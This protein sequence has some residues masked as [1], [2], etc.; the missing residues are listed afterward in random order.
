MGYIVHIKLGGFN[1]L[2][3]IFIPVSDAYNSVYHMKEYCKQR[4]EA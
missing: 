1:G 2:I 4:Q 3:G